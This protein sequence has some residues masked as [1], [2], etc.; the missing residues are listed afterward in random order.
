MK[1]YAKVPEF[2][3]MATLSDEFYYTSDDQNPK[4][5]QNFKLKYFQQVEKLSYD[6]S[7]GGGSPSYSTTGWA[8]RVFFDLP[9]NK[10][11]LKLRYDGII[12]ETG[13]SGD[14][15]TR[16]YR[17]HGEGASVSPFNLNLYT[18]SRLDFAIYSTSSRYIYLIKPKKKG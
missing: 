15:K 14:N 18:N 8:G 5:A 3:G 2:K 13:T 10:G 7:I 1:Q 9:I 11:I 16:Y 12:K 6:H 4:F 17:S